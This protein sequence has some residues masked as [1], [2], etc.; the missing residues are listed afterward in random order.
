LDESVEV[1]DQSLNERKNGDCDGSLLPP[2]LSGSMN[3][4]RLLLKS[5]VPVG[6]A[7][8]F[9]RYSRMFGTEGTHMSCSN[10]VMCHLNRRYM[11]AAPASTADYY[12]NK[13]I[14]VPEYMVYELRIFMRNVYPTS[15]LNDALTQHTFGADN[16][17]VGVEERTSA[18]TFPMGLHFYRLIDL[19]SIPG[20][21]FIP[22]VFASWRHDNEDNGH[23]R[24][25]PIGLSCS[26]IHYA[27][28]PR[29]PHSDRDYAEKI[30]E[31]VEFLGSGVVSVNKSRIALME[32]FTAVRAI[33]YD[34]GPRPT[35]S[36]DLMERYSTM[37]P[38][39][40]LPP[41]QAAPTQ[42]PAPTQPAPSQAAPLSAEA[43]A[44][45]R[46]EEFSPTTWP[47]PAAH[48][49]PRSGEPN[50]RAPPG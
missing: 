22:Y 24:I 8:F 7:Y 45:T 40:Q 14:E 1:E 31:A 23:V 25:I 17:I 38:P 6:A 43:P 47:T 39:A 16:N 26:L 10:C 12:I 44:F 3:D 27:R 35:S 20:M 30:R 4:R 50:W 36:M 29:P 34:M 11:A 9:R 21:D 41:I 49:E 32:A 28:R 19:G 46:R 13:L 2:M 15:L 5:G 42:L 48:S 18:V 37:M 33:G